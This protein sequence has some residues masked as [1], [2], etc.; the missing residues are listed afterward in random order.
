MKKSSWIIGA[1][2]L[3]ALIVFVCLILKLIYMQ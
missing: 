3:I 2:F 1:V